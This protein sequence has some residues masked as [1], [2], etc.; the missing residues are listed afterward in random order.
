MSKKTLLEEGT[1]R[2]FMKLAGTQPL[3]NTFVENSLTD[4]AD[5]KDDDG[6]VEEGLFM[7]DDI[8]GALNSVLEEA[9][10]DELEADEAALDADEDDLEGELDADEEAWDADEA[11]LDIGGEEELDIGGEE[12]G[13][14][15]A[16]EQIRALVSDAVSDAFESAIE[17]GEL[18]VTVG[19]PAEEIDA[20]EFEGGPEDEGDELAVT[21]VDVDVE[22]EPPADEMVAEIARRVA[23]RLLRR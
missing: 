4:A 15:D 1:I 7:E 2:R 16:V 6:P 19:E 14:D 8:E 18:Q 17:A 20:A 21:D 3:S 22:E 10:E 23:K 12:E 13:L 11:E 9:D 5:Y